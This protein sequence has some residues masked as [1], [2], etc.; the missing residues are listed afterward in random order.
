M[1]EPEAVRNLIAHWRWASE[2]GRG[3]A[4]TYI[5]VRD[6][7]QRDAFGRAAAEVERAAGE[8]ADEGLLRLAASLR[9]RSQSGWLPDGVRLPAWPARRPAPSLDAARVHREQQIGYSLALATCASQL[10]EV[11]GGEV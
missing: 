9:E 3:G 1:A 5:R 8:G 2:E 10:H 6:A 4:D 11:A 7:A